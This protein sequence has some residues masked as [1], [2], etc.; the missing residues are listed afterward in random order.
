MALIESEMVSFE[1]CLKITNLPQEAVMRKEVDL[2][3]NYCHQWVSHGKIIFKNFTA[4]Y[5]PNT[6]KVLK[7][8][9][10]EIS[11]GQK[12]GVVGR[13]GAGK[14]TLCLAICRF[15]E[16]SEGRIEIDG[17]DISQVGLNDLRENIIVIP[18]D[19]AIFENTIRFNLDPDKQASDE[20][21]LELLN[22][23]SLINLVSRDAKGLYAGIQESDLSSGEKQ[24]ICICRTI[25]RVSYC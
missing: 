5:R 18:Q 14:S 7:D 11:P 16:A 23:A 22:K 20:Q 6:D 1:R 19:A 10:I 17:V 4:K 24:L 13:A 3:Q 21:I 25:L 9:N 15:L 8:I 12:I 2:G